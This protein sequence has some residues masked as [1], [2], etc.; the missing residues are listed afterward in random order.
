MTVQPPVGTI[1]GEGQTV[2]FGTQWDAFKTNTTGVW[3]QVLN[4]DGT[5]TATPYFIH[6]TQSVD[7]VDNLT[8]GGS[9]S[10]GVVVAIDPNTLD[11]TFAGAA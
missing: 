11:L 6:Y 8:V 5:P 3:L 2:T 1:I 10:Q 9:Y 4:H 7:A